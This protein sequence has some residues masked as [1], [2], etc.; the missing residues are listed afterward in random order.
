MK[1]KTWL[2][3][4]ALLVALCPWAIAQELPSVELFS[5]GMTRIQDRA[6]EDMAALD[7][8]IRLT[9][10]QLFQIRDMSVLSAIMNEMVFSVSAGSHDGVETSSVTVSRQEKPLVHAVIQQTDGQTTLSVDDETYDVTEIAD[11]PGFPGLSEGNTGFLSILRRSVLE[12]MPL[13]DL[14][15]ELTALREGDLLFGLVKITEPFTVIPTTSS[16]GTQISK[17]VVNGAVEAGG[18]PWERLSILPGKLRR[19]RRRSRFPVIRQTG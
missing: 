1:R 6:G 11:I 12:R 9:V 2:L 14:S 15:Q 3:C 5:P 4:V 8:T 16:D 7:E 10:N 19:M 18:K 13:Y 17:L